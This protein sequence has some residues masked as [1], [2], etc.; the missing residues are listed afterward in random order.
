MTVLCGVCSAEN[1]DA[2]KFC[3][4]CGRKIAQAWPQPAAAAA[5]GG[6]GEA[7]LLLG[8]GTAV[9]AP[10]A[11]TAPAAKSRMPSWAVDELPPAPAPLRPQ[12]GNGRWIA[13]LGLL[14]ALLV[15]AAAWWGHRNR[16]PEIAEPAPA[17]Q[18]GPGTAAPAPTLAP[19]LPPPVAQAPP[20]AVPPAVIA[21]KIE[22]APT[23]SEPMLPAAAKPR[24]AP[25]KKQLVPAA[26]PAVEIALPAAPVPAPVRVPS[27]QETCGNL[28]F[29]AKAQCMAAQCARPDV[30]GHAQCEAVRRQQRL[31]EEKRNPTLA[32]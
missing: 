28:N 31:E 20:S 8:A 17:A 29:I 15:L 5:L 3:K 4:G 19:V 6:G 11:P 10:A 18:A 30:T 26:A 22:L 24:K 25:V 21:E 14:V 7:A 23:P 9:A 13:A 32:N 2:A 16:S 1:R 12:I 27:P